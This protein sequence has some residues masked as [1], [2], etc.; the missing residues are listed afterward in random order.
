M[1]RFIFLIA[2]F[3]SFT[4]PTQ[5]PSD[6]IQAVIGVVRAVLFYSPSCGHCHYVMTEVL[7]GL[8]EQYGEQLE[9]IGV[10]ASTQA[11]QALFQSALQYFQLEQA[12]VPFLVAGE[13][14][15]I[16][17]VDIPAKFPKLIEE[18]L[19]N[20]G[21]D[22]PEIPGLAEAMALSV[23]RVQEPTQTTAPSAEAELAKV[24]DSRIEP[25]LE[26]ELA[27][28]EVKPTK[29]LDRLGNDQAGNSLAIMVLA[30]LVVSV[31]G[32]GFYLTGNIKPAPHA[33]H[34]WLIPV[35]GVIGLGVAGYLAYVET[36]QVEAVCGPIG[37]C[38]TVQQSEYA[39][40]F[41]ILPV[42]VLGVMGYAFILA[43]WAAGRLGRG[44][45]E[46]AA[47]MVLF[48]LAVTG[49]VFSIYLTFL[50]PFVIGASCAWCL[51]SAVLMVVTLWLSAP[52]AKRVLNRGLKS[53]LQRDCD[54]CHLT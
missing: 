48:G 53:G 31:I 2:W 30:G 12:G 24:E 13:Q 14:V 6:S 9:I 54:I 50:E 25:I 22:W 23:E 44:R 32:V 47:D 35:I 18:H 17:S 42:G 29:I 5:N 36:S 26:S 34:G 10:D 8:F 27:V 33:N 3:G 20:G 46:A 37:D 52:P 45:I 11:G 1:T 39:R 28:G 21:L 4:V 43:V 19:A 15:L 16:G 51:S 41:G 40:L 7:P 38:N 49:S